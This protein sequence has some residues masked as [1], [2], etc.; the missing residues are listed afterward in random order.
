MLKGEQ[1]FRF[2]MD[3]TRR[4]PHYS[5]IR[6]RTDKNLMV[7]CESCANVV[8][9]CGAAGCGKTAVASEVARAL[10]YPLI[11]IDACVETL[12][13]VGSV[14]YGL[15]P[16]DHDSPR[17]KALF[18][19]PIHEQLFAIARSQVYHAGLRGVVLDAPFTAERRTGPLKLL[20][21]AVRQLT[22]KEDLLPS[23]V[24]SPRSPT[25]RVIAVLVHCE[26]T[27]QERRIR[28]RAKSR[29]SAKLE[30]GSDYFLSCSDTQDVLDLWPQTAEEFVLDDAMHMA[31]RVES[32]A[33]TVNDLGN[34]ISDLCRA[35]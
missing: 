15:R 11:D 19:E 12:V 9:I 35:K 17:Y 13:R 29:D 1:R 32:T 28:Q 27:E 8:L 7:V 34:A 31:C 5:L 2:R 22:C 20:K 14:G 6:A 30:A 33:T 10:Q 25:V 23:E 4:C 21:W 3:S 24:R 18:R 16:G 26:A